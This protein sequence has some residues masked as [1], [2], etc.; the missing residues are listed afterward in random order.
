MTYYDNMTDDQ[1]KEFHDTM[2][3]YGN[4]VLQWINEIYPILI[5][6][7]LNEENNEKI[8]ALNKESKILAAGITELHLEQIPRQAYCYHVRALLLFAS[9]LVDSDTYNEGLNEQENFMTS[10]A[11]TMIL[12]EMDLFLGTV[13]SWLTTFEMT[14]GWE[15]VNENLS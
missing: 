14:N 7:E 10:F 8:D 9:F 3:M 2:E 11:R 13:R 15:V 6:T 12:N 1:V 4:V 5:S